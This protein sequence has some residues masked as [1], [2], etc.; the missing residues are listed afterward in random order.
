MQALRAGW[1]RLAPRERMLVSA[2]A[3][4]LGLAVFWWVAL[5]PALQ[6]LR[7]AEARHRAL[8]AQEQRMLALRAQAQALQS[9]PRVPTEQARRALEGGVAQ[10]FGGAAQVSVLGER[11]TVSLRSVP[12]QAL[13]EWLA[14]IR[15][16]AHAVP[17]EAH[18][19]RSTAGRAASGAPAAPAAVSAAPSAAAPDVRWDGSVVLQ[20]PPTR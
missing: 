8:D 16:T 12:A 14:Q 4:M 10:Q 11:A 1:S 15:A 2:A 7:G 9:Q 18:L 3:T 5:G 17:V 13:A 19:T 20:L 6:T